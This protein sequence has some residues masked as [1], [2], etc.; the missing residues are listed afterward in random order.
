[1][2]PAYFQT[3]A[4]ANQRRHPIPN[5]SSIHP[6]RHVNCLMQPSI[7]CVKHA[8]NGFCTPTSR[9]PTGP[10]P[11]LNPTIPPYL[12]PVT[13]PIPFPPPIENREYPAPQAMPYFPPPVAPPYH[14]QPPV[15]PPYQYQPPVHP[16]YQMRAPYQHQPPVH[17]PYYYPQPLPSLQNGFMVPPSFWGYPLETPEPTPF[18]TPRPTPMPTGQP[19]RAPFSQ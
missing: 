17:P 14:Y 4:G 1:M 15:R 5:K 13:P 18:P 12:S 19:T 3:I 9:Y 16:P 10:T 7:C 11:V 8:T 6:V 2:I